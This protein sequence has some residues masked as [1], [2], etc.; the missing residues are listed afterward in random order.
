MRGYFAAALLSNCP[1]GRTRVM[2]AYPVSLGLVPKSEETGGNRTRSLRLVRRRCPPVCC[3]RSASVQLPHLT[4]RPSAGAE[5]RCTRKR[6]APTG[7]EPLFEGRLTPSPPTQPPRRDAAS[8]PESHAQRNI[9]VLWHALRHSI[10]E[11]YVFSTHD[12]DQEAQKSGQSL[13]QNWQATRTTN[14]T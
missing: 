4:F 9:S 2:F 13:N 8:R 14:R 1:Q 6:G 3:Y 11:C 10:L 7:C 12:Q 5:V